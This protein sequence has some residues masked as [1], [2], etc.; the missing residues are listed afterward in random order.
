[1]QERPQMRVL[2][3]TSSA[4]KLHRPASEVLTVCYRRGW[5]DA[6]CWV[7]G[8]QVKNSAEEPG[9]QGNKV[10]PARDEVRHATAFPASPTRMSAEWSARWLPV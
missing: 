10:S 3:S 6:C 4:V 2:R 7:T 1:M 9:K 5:L 8:G